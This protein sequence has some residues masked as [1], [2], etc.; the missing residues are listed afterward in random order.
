MIVAFVKSWCVYIVYLHIT[1][2]WIYMYMYT[3]MQYK[4]RSALRK[5]EVDAL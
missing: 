1:P 2:K 4:T 5:G 3:G